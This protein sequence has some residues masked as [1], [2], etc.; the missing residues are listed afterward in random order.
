MIDASDSMLLLTLIYLS[1]ILWH[2]DEATAE[3]S[4]SLWSL[5]WPVALWLNC[6]RQACKKALSYVC[7]SAM[8]RFGVTGK[9]LCFQFGGTSD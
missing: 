2:L 4:S 7:R 5:L 9:F 3:R 6:A 8:R 1:G